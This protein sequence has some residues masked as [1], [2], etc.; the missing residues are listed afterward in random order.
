MREDTPRKPHWAWSSCPRSCWCLF[1]LSV[2]HQTLRLCVLFAQQEAALSCWIGCLLMCKRPST[3][4]KQLVTVL[5][6]LGEEDARPTSGQLRCA[7]ACNHTHIHIIADIHVVLTKQL[8]SQ[9]HAL[10]SEKRIVAHSLRTDARS[11]PSK[12]SWSNMWEHRKIYCW[13]MWL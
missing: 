5:L 11:S 1:R 7:R 4:G 8:P 13:P 6:R 2:G 3:T 12:C 9:R 10:S